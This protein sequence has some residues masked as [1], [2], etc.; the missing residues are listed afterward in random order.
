MTVEVH[1]VNHTALIRTAARWKIPRGIALIAIARDVRCIY[2]NRKFDVDLSGPRAGFASWEHIIN[3]ETIV[4]PENIAL[5]CMGCNSSKGTKSL[6][7]W[8]DSAYCQMRGINPATIAPTAARS[9][10]ESE[11]IA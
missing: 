6:R 11:S 3:D 4:T 9:L 8:L 2:C 5:C 10:K 7:D 1:P